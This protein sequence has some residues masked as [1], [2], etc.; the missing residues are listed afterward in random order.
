MKTYIWMWAFFFAFVSHAQFKSGENVTIT[1]PQDD[2]IYLAG[3]A[4]NINNK[5]RGDVV[6]SG[7]SIFVLDSISQDLIAAGGELAFKGYVAD[8][9]RAAGGKLLIDAEIG[10]DVV[11]AGGK[12]HIGNNS[13]IHGNLI[14]FSGEL[15]INGDVMG[16]MKASTGKASIYGTIGKDAKISGG[17]IYLDGDFKG[18]TQ[19]TAEHLTIGNNAKFYGAVTYWTKEGEV[20]FKNSLVGTTATF[21]EDLRMEKEE[22]SLYNFGAFSFGLALFYILSILVIIILFHALFKNQFPTITTDVEGNTWNV[23]G[24]GLIYLFG[25]PLLILITCITL[26]GI[27]IGLFI[28]VTYLFSLL[29]GH[30]LA[31]LLFT[32]YWN[33]RNEKQWGFWAMVFLTLG[34][35]LILRLVTLVP[36]LGWII[37]VVALSFTYGLFIKKVIRKKQAVV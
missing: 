32:Y 23:L 7:G 16:T 2:D 31:A 30:V 6:A 22:L 24:N 20:D 9:V 1:Q 15:Q 35:A 36:I 11:V 21:T 33:Q 26:I 18:N 28:L 29:F 12:I 25:V 8:D 5:V 27:P 34:F 14:S 4:V 17:E 10:D 37:S 13:I 3:E 19:I